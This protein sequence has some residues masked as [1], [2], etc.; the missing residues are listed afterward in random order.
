MDN[1]REHIVHTRAATRS[2]LLPAPK[3]LFSPQA[4][5]FGTTGVNLVDYPLLA[6]ASGVSVASAARPS[7]SA[8]PTP[9]PAGG[10]PFTSVSRTPSPSVVDDEEN[11]SELPLLTRSNAD[12]GARNSSAAPGDLDEGWTTVSHK[13]SRSHRERRGSPSRVK[14]TSNDNNSD[15]GSESTFAQATDEMSSEE[16]QDLIRRH[17]RI[18][19]DF[20]LRLERKATPEKSQL[21]TVDSSVNA[22]TFGEAPSFAESGSNGEPAPVVQV[23][24]V[25]AAKSLRATMEE[26][27]DEGDLISFN[28]VAGPS[29]SKGKGPDPL[30]RW[31]AAMIF[32]NSQ[33]RTQTS[34]A[35][36]PA[37]KIHQCSK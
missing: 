25:V 27:E 23:N 4:I 29:K 11:S 31:P 35:R 37:I 19:E 22:P 33:C 17:E 2:G 8:R 20:R 1:N 21:Y 14:H 6:P 9:A 13:T 7:A 10:I 18:A 16:L 34:H 26:V 5:T 36:H 15:S 32:G 3:P 24:P 28:A 30:E 12:A